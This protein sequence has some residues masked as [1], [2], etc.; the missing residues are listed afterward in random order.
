LIAPTQRALA[1][2]L[3][4]L[5]HAAASAEVSTRPRAA[6]GVR[7]I[8]ASESAPATVV[9]DIREV[10]DLD[11]HGRSARLEVVRV[12]DGPLEKA[13]AVTIVWEE[14]AASRASRFA[15]GERILVSL[16]ALPGHSIWRTRLPDAEE[17][18]RSVAV[19]MRGEA[20]LR[21]PAP[22]SLDALEHY[23]RLADEQREGAT[24]A[25]YLV[26]LVARAEL[27]L[28][29]N[30]VERLASHTR[31]ER[32]IDGGLGEQLA[33]AFERADATDAFRGALAALIGDRQLEAT[34]PAL[35]RLADRDPLASPEVYEALARL[36]GGLSPER[37]SALLA[38]APAAQ[39][40]VAVSHLDGP[41]AVPTLERL[42][43]RDDAPAVR[44]A[45]GER[46]AELRGEAALE[47]L[48]G[49]LADPAASVRGTAAR[50]LGAQGEPAVAPLRQVI[51]GNDP[52]AA[53][54]AVV[55]LGLNPAPGARA[56]LREIATGHPEARVRKLAE[57]SLG[58]AIGHEH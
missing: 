28:A 37:S 5:G 50:L 39:R 49:A 7:L 57:L 48:L 43:R 14:L 21:E 58:G 34:R 29:A 12:L 11:R 47:P 30:A 19:A 52:D 31:L 33:L 32:E 27:P 51:D 6:G 56:A 41:T 8:E 45:A 24:G 36:D 55:A 35:E 1:V 2:A 42:L 13:S 40:R 10:R 54:A 9:G 23:L 26:A 38:S 22:G 4:L 15:K 17:R 53:S 3:A 25:G 20:F 44:A 16:E 18:G 46:L